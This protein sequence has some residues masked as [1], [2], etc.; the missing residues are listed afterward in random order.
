MSNA[1]QNEF[2]YI[3]GTC[4]IGPAEIR[5][6]RNLSFYAL[7]VLLLMAV[8]LFLFSDQKLLRLLL[9]IP[10]SAFGVSAI[11]WLTKF[12][13]KFGL[14]GIFNFRQ[15]GQ[16]QSVMQEE[17]RRKDLAKARTIILSGTL[18]GAAITAIAYFLP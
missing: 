15:T 14:K 9:I 17:F 11:Q 1:P 2:E 4:N 3:P 8:P 7:L 16:S 18:V 12:C 13:V 10:A 6:R 5:R